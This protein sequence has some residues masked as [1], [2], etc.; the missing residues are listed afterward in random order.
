MKEPSE[1]AIRRKLIIT[2]HVTADRRVTVSF[3][4][5]SPE[6]FLLGEGDFIRGS[7]F[8]DNRK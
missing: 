2:A 5:K 3:E 6:H 4:Q 7:H 1:V 8:P